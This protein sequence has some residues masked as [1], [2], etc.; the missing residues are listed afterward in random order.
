MLIEIAKKLLNSLH[1]FFALIPV[2]IFFIP[3]RFVKF[4]AHWLLLGAIMVPLH[5]VFTDNQCLLTMISKRLGDYKDSK[6]NSEFTE[7][8]L[9]WIYL[10]IM[11]VFDWKWDNDG[12]QKMSTFHWGMN[13]LFIWYYS[14]YFTGYVA[15]NR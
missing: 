4:Y 11:R 9:K 13:I 1:V 15:I 6:T 7:R 3:I 8:N 12:L 5:W 14:F 10:P 2:L